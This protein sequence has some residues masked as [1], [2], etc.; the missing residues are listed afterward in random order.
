M[1]TEKTQ[2]L[3][4]PDREFK[5]VIMECSSKSLRMRIKQKKNSL[6]EAVKKSQREILELKNLVTE[7]L[8]LQWMSSTAE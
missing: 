5:A 7:T 3:E 2:M 8:Q 1:N 6:S 4:L